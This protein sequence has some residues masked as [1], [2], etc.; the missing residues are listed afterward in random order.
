M[1][2][3]LVFK[4][5][6][7]I[8]SIIAL[9]QCLGFCLKRLYENM[10]AETQEGK[11]LYA[12]SDN[13]FE[14]IILG[15]SRAAHHY[16]TGLIGKNTSKKVYNFGA[17][18]QSIFYQYASLLL[19]SKKHKPELVILDVYPIDLLNY[20]ISDYDRLSELKFLYGYNSTIDTL[21]LFKDKY[22]Y[23][24]LYSKLYR[25]N[26]KILKLINYSFRKQ[27]EDDLMGF[28]PL[29]KRMKDYYPILNYNEFK[30][31]TKK[32][33]ILLDLIDFCNINQISLVLCVSPYWGKE[34]VPMVEA[35][36]YLM[37][38][39]ES[40]KVKLYDFCNSKNFGFNYYH[41]SDPLHLNEYGALKFTQ[42][43]LERGTS[44]FINNHM[45]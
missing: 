14:I 16:N 25:Y 11:L 35:N 30:I 33:N 19:A 41:F 39:I 31:D 3:K 20:S 24:K 45:Q 12:K 22:E 43:L 26:S 9:D 15:S 42:L 36:K 34:S 17:D 44:D 29:S 21:I 8:F 37:K 1:Q 10:P 27:R 2:K 7:F 38:I 6:F 4:S 13:K 5:I 23:L 18:G 28:S 40:K 32:V